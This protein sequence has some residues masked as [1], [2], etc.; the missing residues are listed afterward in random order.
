MSHELAHFDLVRVT[1]SEAVQ[2]GAELLL[3][4]NVAA[5]DL[6]RGRRLVSAQYVVE[7]VHR[8]GEP[9]GPS[10]VDA[11][12]ARSAD[13]P[14]LPPVTFLQYEAGTWVANGHVPATAFLIVR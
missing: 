5:A 8:A 3:L 13:Y 9:G 14:S 6:P 12:T 4:S 11:I 2:P 1:A 10:T 7:S